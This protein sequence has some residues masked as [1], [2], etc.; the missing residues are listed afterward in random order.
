NTEAVTSLDISKSPDKVGSAAMK[1]TK[2]PG[3]LDI[4]PGP[5]NDSHWLYEV[6]V[7]KSVFGDAFTKYTDLDISWTMNCANDVITVRDDILTIDEPP[8]WALLGST[9]PVVF[10]RRRR[11]AIR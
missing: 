11:S 5:A 7:D 3:A 10:W 6:S 8:V 1:V 9:L 2:L 4:G